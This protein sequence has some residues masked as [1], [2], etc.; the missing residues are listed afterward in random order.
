MDPQTKV[1]ARRAIVWSAISY[2]PLVAGSVWAVFAL[3][4]WIGLRGQLFAGSGLL[5][6][7]AA[8]SPVFL[9]VLRL[10]NPT[11]RFMG[12]SITG[13]TVASVS[14]AILVAAALAIIAVTVPLK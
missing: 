9:P 2:V 7:I 3:G 14:A 4:Q 6:G 5:V 10:R 13:Y 11:R 12:V 8:S 1:V